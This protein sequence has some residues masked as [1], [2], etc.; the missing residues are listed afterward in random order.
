M[1][2]HASTR[3]DTP[4]HA[5]ALLLLLLAHA[6]ILSGDTP[7]GAEPECGRQRE[8]GR[9]V[10]G[11]AARP[12]EWPWQVSL[13]LRGEHFCGGTLV[14]P[15]WVLS[16]AHCFQGPNGSRAEPREWRAVV[17]RLRLEE[18]GGQERTVVEVVV[19]E[20]YR[21]V[22][23]GHDLALARLESPVTLGSRVGTICLPQA[24]HPFAFGTPCW[25]TGWGHVAENVS[26]P[27]GSP[28]QKVAL[29]LLSRK[30][31]NCLYSNLRNRELARPARHG[32][33]C[34]GGQEGGRGA[35]QADSGGP[36]ACGGPGGQWVQAG[37]L[38]FAVGCARPN[39][40]VLATGLVAH[41]GW[42][43]RRLPP[44]VFAP[45]GPPPPPGLED[46]KCLG[47]GMQGG[48]QLDA[49]PG[50]SWPWAVSLRLRGEHR[51]G[52]ALVAE[53]WVL[54]AA[55]CFIGQQAAE[56]WE[57]VA[58]G[59]TRRKG[60]RLHL[61][62]A[63]VEPGGGRDLALL[64]LETPLPLG[65]TL[66]PLCLPYS[67]H[68]RPPGTRCWALLAP[69][70]SSI[71]EKLVNVE[72]TLSESCGTRGDLRDDEGVLSPPDT[73][74]ITVPEGTSACQPDG[75]SALV[76]EERGIWFLMGTATVGG[77]AQGGPPL[78]TAAPHYE[79]WIAGI[80]REAYFA[81]TPPD[82]REEEE[83]EEE[84]EPTEDPGAREHPKPTE[85]PGFGGGPNT[86]R[87]AQVPEGTDVRGY[88]ESWGDPEIWESSGKA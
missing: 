15:Q 75:G 88:P 55:H 66:R 48:P 68:Q 72:V 24:N 63:Y 26:L 2:R 33:V 71:P 25:I 3:L 29:D 51:C 58:A 39:G 86:W 61:H 56:A 1:A 73:F 79:R 6:E 44:T 81:E 65:P 13:Q 32:M 41:A 34:A 17:G 49:P 19:H 9:V 38:S 70:G 78:F 42:L 43:R 54:T 7:A 4:G 76:C 16:A 50:P 53:S 62:G 84:K 57:A 11:T 18:T 40:P 87:R 36:L 5:A 21:R 10:G 74:C 27:A 30:T 45:P 85:N 35:C 67:E 23:G 59:D 77:C 28:L 31:C 8:L 80:T 12:G 69:N 47:C 20:G 14:T 52:G 22:E 82:P 37:V 83:E 64:R 60:A 46:G